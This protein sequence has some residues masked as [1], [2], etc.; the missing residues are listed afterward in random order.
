M[1]RSY[2]MMSLITIAVFAFT[3]PAVFADSCD[4]CPTGGECSF[5]SCQ[6]DGDCYECG[7]ECDSMNCYYDTC[8]GT[9][10]TCVVE[11]GN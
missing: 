11:E 10:G 9:V 8:T 1:F 4:D 3:P 5:E 2:I 6:K 7:Y